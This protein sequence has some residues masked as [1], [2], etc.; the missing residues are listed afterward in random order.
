MKTLFLEARKQHNRIVFPSMDFLPQKIGLLYTI[1]FKDT[2][3]LLKSHLE[4]MGKKVFIGKG[5]LAY[6]GQVLGC[7]ASSARAIESKVDCFVIITSGK[8]HASSVFLSIEKPLYILGDE[9]IEKVDIEYF[10]QKR[11]AALSKFLFSD[12]I[13]ILVTTKPGQQKFKQALKLKEELEK[14]DK[15][16]HIFIADNININEFENF[17]I[18]FWVNTACSGLIFDSQKI[19]NLEEYY[20]IK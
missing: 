2:L 5:N 16:C 8:W 18:D 4:S 1:Q 11:K 9:K 15:I 13:G 14:K 6:D 3:P 12:R 10:K 7:D 19:I 20:S 17:K